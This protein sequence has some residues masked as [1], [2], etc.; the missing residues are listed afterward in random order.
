MSF[1]P[2][3][4]VLQRSTP[5]PRSAPTDTG[6]WHI[7]GLTD[8][9]PIIPTL[10]SSMADYERIFGARV[11]YSVL[12]D[13]LDLYFREGGSRAIISRVVGPAATV[14]TKNLLDAGAAISLVA[15]ATGPGAGSALISVGVRAGGAGGTFVIFVVVGGIEVET[16]PDLVDNN[17]AVLWG[18]GSNYIRL[19]LG[20][21]A[22]DP[23]VVAAGALSAGTDDRANIVDAQWQTA[24]DRLTAD[25]GP[26]QVS[27]PGRTTT[28]GHTQL[29]AH[30]AATRRVAI[31]DA[32]DSPTQA[33]L[34]TASAAARAG[35]QRFGGMFA[36]W[37]SAPGVVAGTIRI[38]PPSGLVAGKL[39]KNDAAGLGAAEP[40]AGDNGESA[41]ATGLSQV[42]WSDSVRQVL[43]NAGINVI[44][45]VFGSVR[46]Y[47]WRSLVDAVADP[48]WIALG[49]VRLYMAISAN[50]ASIAEA[51]LFDKIDG[52]GKKI[53]EF[54]G[55]L[56]GL[57]M[58]YYS[59]NDLY[60]VT[61][62]EA[63]YVDVGNQVNTPVRLAANELHAVL[64]VKMSPFGEFVQIEIVKR[65]ITEGVS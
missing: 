36:P 57:L 9:G 8:S 21:S 22:N 45:S 6:I 24:L 23:A 58:D 35:N 12:Y 17:A 64:N 60:G 32:P 7:V 1:R 26:G 13:A 40:A 25:L 51:F 38:I 10:I 27:A 4:S 37:I 55:A 16:S 56:R 59:N 46:I 63:F 43:N 2:G 34:T 18:A 5:P 20:A 33:T 41:F 28:T 47:G 53:A 52:Q 30:A 54:G 44:R 62:E 19:A 15:S 11:S 49:S 39:S 42:A 65:P 48:D 14:G 3:V 61:P 29:L 50:A 31:L